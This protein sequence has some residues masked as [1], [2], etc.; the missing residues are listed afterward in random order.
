MYDDGCEKCL[1]TNWDNVNNSLRF[2]ILSRMNKKVLSCI[3]CL[4][5]PFLRDCIDS[6][7]EPFLRDVFSCLITYLE[8]QYAVKFFIP[9]CVA[10]TG[11]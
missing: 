2:Y 11:I 10:S 1:L 5:E 9:G 7:G 4:G 3:D 8:K 6:L